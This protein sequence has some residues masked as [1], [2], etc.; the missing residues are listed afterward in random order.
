LTLAAAQFAKGGMK[1]PCGFYVSPIFDHDFA[2]DTAF[3]APN[4]TV[5]VPALLWAFDLVR[6][7]L[8]KIG[9]DFDI[10][11]VFIDPGSSDSIAAFDDA[12]AIF[13]GGAVNMA[14]GEARIGPVAAQRDFKGS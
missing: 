7:H 3:F 2:H 8:T 13:A 10:G 5:A 9:G 11:G 4:P 1:L 12:K 6:D 14:I